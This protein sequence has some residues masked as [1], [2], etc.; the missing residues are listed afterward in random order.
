M[1]AI[2]TASRIEAAAALLLEARRA[3]TPLDALP[4]ACRPR[5]LLEGYAIQE[6]LV[7]LDGRPVGGWKI[8]CTSDYAQKLLGVDQPFPGRVF[9]ETI[10]SSPA[11][12][13][14]K[15][16]IAIGL[17]PEF[18]FRLWR[19]LPPRATAYSRLEVESAVSSLH[20]AFEIVETRYRAWAGVGGPSL[21]ADNGANGALIAGDGVRDWRRFDLAAH[22]LALSIN[23]Q[24]VAEGTGA[25][26]LGHPLEALAWLANDM[27]LHGPG[28]KA[29]EI[30]T[31]GTCGGIH[32]LKARDEAV[33][34]YGALGEVSLRVV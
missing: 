16:F 4:E 17:E 13:S 31:T 7:A 2:E 34:D 23:G 18:A 24:T 22:K 15:D 26:A 1:T 11:V 6:T 32:F 33:A 27:R 25:A 14:A 5:D 9:A 10:L 28:L 12:V 30:V 3:H 8:G 19:D 21:V 29:G 20:P